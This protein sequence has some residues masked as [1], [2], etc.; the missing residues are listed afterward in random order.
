[1]IA[2]RRILLDGPDKPRSVWLGRLD[3]GFAVEFINAEGDVKRL[4]LTE[5]A[6][7]GLRDLYMAELAHP[8]ADEGPQYYVAI[9]DAEDDNPWSVTRQEPDDV[10]K[11]KGAE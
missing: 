6:L 2:G 3:D 4:A 8:A 10:V 7:L 9:H 11:T 1:M 5:E